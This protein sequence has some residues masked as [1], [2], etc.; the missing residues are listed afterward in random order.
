MSAS[1]SIPAEKMDTAS[2]SSLVL[3]TSSPASSAR[4]YDLEGSSDNSSQ[5]ISPT[6]KDGVPVNYSLPKCFSA[7]VMESLEKKDMKPNVRSA[8]VRELIV[9][10]T[11]YGVKPPKNFCSTVARKI[12]L[13]YPFLRDA[14][15]SGYVSICNCGLNVLVVS[16][17]VQA[18][19]EKRLIGRV[20]NVSK[21]DKKRQSEE[22]EASPPAKKR[23][24][25][26]DRYPPLSPSDI[27]DESTHERHM[28]A[29]KDELA[30]DKP[31][32]CVL[33]EL[34]ELTFCHRREFVL[35]YATSVDE[36]LMTYPA[37]RQPDVVS[38]LKCDHTYTCKLIVH[39]MGVGL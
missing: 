13:K 5:S 35:S 19:W 28:K 39:A 4:S 15:G 33:Q 37:L 10:M 38:T 7:G 3:P 11:S 6:F 8:F 26:L 18:S 22:E 17:S 23:P 29:I 31:R 32:T 2:G 34:M 9:H 27:T 30:R 12:V 36:I 1:D 24:K 14:V 25:L 21:G 16:N 20:Y